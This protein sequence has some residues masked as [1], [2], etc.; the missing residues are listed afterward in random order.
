MELADLQLGRK[1]V[2]VVIYIVG[3]MVGNQPFSSKPSLYALS[4]FAALPRC[5]PV[6]GKSRE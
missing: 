2:Y 5:S 4:G 1:C 6:Q 3:V